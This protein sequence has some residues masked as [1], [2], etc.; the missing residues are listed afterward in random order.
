MFD[1][2]RSSDFKASAVLRKGSIKDL[3]GIKNVERIAFGE[4]AYDD[5]SLKYMLKKTNAVTMIYETEGK[6]V[7][8]A[9]VYIGKS[10]RTSHIESIAVDPSYQGSG[11]GRKLLNEVE[12][13]SQSE[14]CER[15]VLET[16]EGNSLALGLYVKNGYSVVKTVKEYY[17]IPYNG[18]RNA[19][20][21][22][23]SLNKK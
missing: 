5:S 6:I 18:S 3:E 23:K 13:I 4:H 9:T 17:T 8:Y 14:G 15:I 11:L 19:I 2:A 12:R 1:R 7:G 20:R 10:S 16:F 21:L 22:S